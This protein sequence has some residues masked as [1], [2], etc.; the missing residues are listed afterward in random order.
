M[1]R[2]GSSAAWQKPFDVVLWDLP[3]LSQSPAALLLARH[4]DGIVLV[5]QARR[6]RRDAASES[7]HRLESAGGKVLGLVLNRTW[8]FTPRWVLRFL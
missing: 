1:C 6:T 7:A 2:N 5:A 8:S 3:A 4:A